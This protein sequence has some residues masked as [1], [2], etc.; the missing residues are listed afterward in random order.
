MTPCTFILRVHD[1]DP[2]RVEAMIGC[3]RE[4]AGSKPDHK[5]GI[6]GSTIY[7]FKG[8]ACYAHWTKAR[9]IV[10]K[11]WEVADGS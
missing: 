11:S 7:G 4:F 1:F 5:A 3:A 6:G 9:A 8:W 2:L 10:V